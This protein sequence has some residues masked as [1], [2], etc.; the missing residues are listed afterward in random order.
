MLIINEDVEFLIEIFPNFIKKPLKLNYNLNE[1]V[2]IIIDVGK[3]PEARFKSG[4]EILS[5]RAISKQ[6][7]NY[8]LKK[9]TNFNEKNR[10]GIK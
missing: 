7:I 1:L 9:I 2:E 4:I 5:Y 3:C 8:C 10:S 6:D